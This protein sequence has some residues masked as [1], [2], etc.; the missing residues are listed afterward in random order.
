MGRHSDTGKLGDQI[1]YTGS[2]TTRGVEIEQRVRDR[3]HSLGIG[4][5]RT[6]RERAAV[7]SFV[8]AHEQLLVDEYGCRSSLWKRSYTFVIPVVSLT[9]SI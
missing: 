8:G 6:R 2:S 5:S 1:T 7:L 9:T 4:D 3:R